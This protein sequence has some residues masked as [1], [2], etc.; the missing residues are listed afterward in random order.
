[1]ENFAVL[2]NNITKTFKLPKPQGEKNIF[3]RK[4]NFSGS[5]V[6][7][8]LNEI[9]FTVKKGEILG[10]IGFN[11]SGKTTL[12][13]VISGV[14]KP[15]SGSVKINGQISPLLQLGAGFQGDLAAEENIIMNGM[16]LGL[17][18]S[19]IKEKVNDIIE[20][21]E[22]EKFSQM[23]LKHYSTGMKARLT[24]ATA[25]QINPDILLVD[26]IQAVG[27]IN[28]REKSYQTFLSFKKRNKTIIHTTH[29]LSKLSEYSDRVLLLHKGK[30]IM[31]GNPDDV[32]KN[33]MKL[34][35]A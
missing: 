17:P 1:M 15:D 25:M 3:K 31:I 16:L 13:R 35:S 29:N 11:G 4:L 18:K 33:Y 2:V 23:K 7:T 19:S 27:D 12:L 24:F 28:F 22:L 32:I 6:F 9:S 5:E 34:K 26:E 30:N 14:Y 8:A 21:A 10:I 20:F